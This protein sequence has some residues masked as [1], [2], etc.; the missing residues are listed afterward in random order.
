MEEEGGVAH[1]D[2]GILLAYYSPWFLYDCTNMHDCIS[3]H[4]SEEA[5]DRRKW[6][7]KKEASS[8]KM[9]ES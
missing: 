4:L 7:R 5:G 6:K 9:M 8:I 3:D 2:D 1:K